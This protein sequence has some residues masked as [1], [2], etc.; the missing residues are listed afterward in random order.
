M[1]NIVKIAVLLILT[2]AGT[3]ALAAEVLPQADKSAPCLQPIA[4]TQPADARGA[5]PAGREKEEPPPSPIEASACNKTS[6]ISTYKIN[7]FT[8]NNWWTNE[9][10]Q[11]KFQFSVKYKFF[12]RDISIQGRPLSLYFA[13]TQKSLW[14]VGQTSMPFEE[15]NYNPEAFFDYRINHSWGR[16]SLRDIILSPFEHESN[17]LAGP[18]SRGWNRLY[19]AVRLGFLPME[20]QCEAESEQK[21]HIELNMKLWHAFGYSDEA[22][23][24]QSLGSTETFLDYE[25]YGEINLVLRD[26]IVQGEWGNR[27]DVTSRIGGKENYEIEYQQK[28]PHLNFSPYIQYWNGYDETLLRFD[29]F[30]KRA[31]VGVSFSL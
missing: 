6:P 17:G 31:F 19:A 8:I 20:Q 27:L 21:D 15:S 3:D 2:C 1:K 29:R 18:D 25:G 4:E 7:Y 22:A 28:M 5:E 24:L 16:F 10:A 9:N 23:Y 12:N 11:V 30:G 13:Y 26:V 14:D